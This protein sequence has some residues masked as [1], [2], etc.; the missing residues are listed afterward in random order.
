[1][2]KT[3][4]SAPRLN[5]WTG[6]SH[7]FLYEK[8]SSS[9]NYY[10][11]KEV[12]FFIANVGTPVVVAFQETLQMHSEDEVL[13]RFYH[14][15][16]V[17]SKIESLTEYYK[18]HTE[19]PRLF[20]QPSCEIVNRFHDKKR[21]LNY[22]RITKMIGIPA[23]ERIEIQDSQT[24]NSKSHNTT[25]SV[26]P[27]LL[28]LL[29]LDLKNDL[30]RQRERRE[31]KQ[32][33]KES[34]LSTSVTVRDLNNFL[35]TVFKEEETKISDVPKVRQRQIK[36]CPKLF[37]KLHLNFNKNFM[38]QRPLI[39]K[40]DSVVQF[41]SLKSSIK[42]ATKN[43]ESNQI[44][45]NFK[46]GKEPSVNG[47]SQASLRKEE[48][49]SKPLKLSD[50]KKEKK[51]PNLKM[52]LNRQF[53]NCSINNLNI[54]I[55]MQTLN[56]NNKQAKEFQNTASEKN[57][58]NIQFDVP[59]SSPW[60]IPHVS[61][62]VE[63]PTFSL[64]EKYKGAQKEKKPGNEAVIDETNRIVGKGP[65]TKQTGL[66]KS[67]ERTHV[68]KMP[69]RGGSFKTDGKFETAL[70]N[71]VHL[72]TNPS[73]GNAEKLQ[74]S[75]YAHKQ[76]DRNSNR[77]GLSNVLKE[78]ISKQKQLGTS[79]STMNNFHKKN[80]SKP[81]LKLASEK[82]NEQSNKFRSTRS[83]NTR[84]NNNLSRATRPVNLMYK[85]VEKLEAA[86]SD[87]AS[88]LPV[89]GP[90]KSNDFFGTFKQFESQDNNFLKSKK[91]ESLKNKKN[92]LQKDVKH[93]SKNEAVLKSKILHPK[94]KS[95]QK[96]HTPNNIFQNILEEV[97]Q[98]QRSRNGT[99]KNQEA[100]RKRIFDGNF[101]AP[102][103]A[104]KSKQ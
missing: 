79:E 6:F 96:R 100:S 33:E 53:K 4:P 95:E 26:H 60:L 15:R 69:I 73:R 67:V 94:Q 47:P 98:R 58:A 39:S 89:L 50:S 28:S 85:M 23:E 52:S 57:K 36:F 70:Q 102:K 21:K 24:M 83:I 20:I 72:Q 2:K 3:P 42:R 75:L 7:R 78:V 77:E 40:T 92:L 18:F 65:R 99:K 19:V 93:F 84:N 103:Q 48:R 13:R 22:I 34:K 25:S 5:R 35:T 32:V 82:Y 54:N 1:M 81:P 63:S 56:S 31:R 68:L 16:E 64:L 27:S 8:Y 17:W 62:K 11:M 71:P 101:K 91:P 46:K 51:S 41:N 29:P 30:N 104:L 87:L 14:K 55:Q 90:P 59:M 44:F 61:I 66:I 37:N 74:T 49:S 43:P 80:P 97:L 86:K 10:Y 45:K 9:Q 76:M 38:Q 88:T 12:N